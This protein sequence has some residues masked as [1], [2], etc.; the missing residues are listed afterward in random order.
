[1]TS[2]IIFVNKKLFQICK[3]K[4]SIFLL[5]T[6]KEVDKIHGSEQGVR[7]IRTG[8]EGTRDLLLVASVDGII[9]IRD[10]RSGLFI[11]SIMGHTKTPLDMQVSYISG[12]CILNR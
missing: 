3:D 6:M 2:K 12:T 10:I 5:E 9:S 8:K 11:R 4:G 7:C 1:M